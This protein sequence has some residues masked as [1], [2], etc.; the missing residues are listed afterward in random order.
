M[1][2]NF[3]EF[4]FMKCTLCTQIAPAQCFD[5]KRHTFSSYKLQIASHNSLRRTVYMKF[6][7]VLFEKC[8]QM[9]VQVI[10]RQQFCARR[11]YYRLYMGHC[12]CIMQS[13]LLL[14]WFYCSHFERKNYAKVWANNRC[15]T[16]YPFTVLDSLAFEQFGAPFRCIGVWVFADFKIEL[17]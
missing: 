14:E 7:P 16:T 3:I 10:A 2:H 11:T 5:M 17:K 4:F 12:I 6:N 9:A 1:F 8:L 13:L 15:G